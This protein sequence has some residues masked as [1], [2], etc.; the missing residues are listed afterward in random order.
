MSTSL[1]ELLSAE[2]E[3]P[4]R[5]RPPAGQF[6]GRQVLRLALLAAALAGAAWVVLY[7]VNVVIDYWFLFL[8]AAALIAVRRVAVAMRPDPD[9][10]ARPDR[11]PEA[12]DL[13]FPARPFAEARRWADRLDW[14]DR[15]AGRF[16]RRVR[17][18]LVQI[19]D[20]RLRQRHGL[21]LNGDPGRA[22]T[23]LGDPLW[24]VLTAPEP[25]AP[26]PRDLAALL[27]RVEEL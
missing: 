21:T 5:R 22:R 12:G 17:P 14:M 18:A 24:T 6:G 9:L 11:D 23:L 19:V 4:R 15:D 3:R 16:R 20:E 8:V 26:T 2:P 27:A 1:D 7:V 13:A 25:K 10:V